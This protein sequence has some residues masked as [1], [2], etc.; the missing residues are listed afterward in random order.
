MRMTRVFRFLI[1]LLGLAMPAQAATGTLFPSPWF[2]ALDV[3]G[4]PIA[5]AKGCF[6]SAGTSTPAT[7]YSDV[8]LTTPNANPI[9]ANSSG[10][11]GPVYLTPGQ[12]YKFILQDATGTAGNCDGAVVRTQDNIAAVPTSSGVVDITG[13]A[14]E[15][16]TAGQAVYLSAGDGGKTQ[17]SWYKADSAN[18]YSSTTNYVGIATVTIGSGNQGNIR[19]AGSVTSLTVS[20]GT[21]YYIGTAGALTST[22]PVNARLLGEADTATSLVLLARDLTPFVFVNDFRLSLTTATC[23]PAADVTGAS[24]ATLFLTP[25]TGNRITLFDA[26]GNVETCTTAELSI[27]VP[28]TTSQM[29]D[30]WAVDS[31]G[32]VPT[33]E[34]L[35]WTNDTTRATAVAR[36]NGRWVKSGAPTRMFLGS[37]RTGTVSGQTEDSAA[38]RYLWNL[39]NK[40]DRYLEISDATASWN[41]T[42]ATW[43]QARATAANQVDLIV[44]L[45]EDRL[46]VNLLGGAS[47]GTQAWVN[48]GIGEDSTTTPTAQAIG[49]NQLVGSAAVVQLAATL[50][51]VP[52]V[53]RH[54]Y[55]WLEGS[56]A[57]G[58]T[59]FYGNNA[60]VGGNSLTS[61][62][63]AL[64]RN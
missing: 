35:A 29:Y 14:G 62:L 45:A 7:T 8:L 38:K 39:Y 18:P 51:K 3:N 11:I 30:V 20:A 49:G 41:Y 46:I 47:N 44:G 21:K 13:T 12:S 33:L 63:W 42:T 22:A 24:A 52:A 32:C 40:A 48:V 1:L 54:F 25:C 19:I 61:H 9:R 16:I 26:S 55:V 36:T 64:W 53:G 2:T 5:L 50:D 10:V 6:Y 59:T 23:V 56:Q 43:R 28:A 17:G 58:T 34:L 57:A 31:G 4:N 60:T 27:A 15:A 37:M